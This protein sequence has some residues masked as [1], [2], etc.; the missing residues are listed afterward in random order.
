MSNV[1]RVKRR[2]S[3]GSG[4]PTTLQLGN[5]EIAYNEVDDT[6][7]YGK[8]GTPAAAASVVKVG[9]VGNFLPLTGG[10]LTGSLTINPGNLALGSTFAANTIDL[11]QHVA[12]YSTT[13]GL[14]VS[15]LPQLNLVAGGAAVM[16][17][18]ATTV[19]LPVGTIFAATGS[20]TFNNWITINSN[21]SGYLPTSGQGA[22]GWNFTGGS[23]DIDFFNTSPTAASSFRF[24][25]I[26][27]AAPPRWTGNTA[28]AL[29]ANVQNDANGRIYICTVAGTSAA[30][31]GPTGTGAGIVDGTVTWNFVSASSANASLLVEMLPTLTRFSTG[32]SFGS[33]LGASNADLSKHI[34]LF[35]TNYGINVTS[36]QMNLV[37]AG[38]PTVQIIGNTVKV[39]AGLQLDT[40]Q[41]TGRSL[42]YQASGLNRWA[43]QVLV[44]ESGTGNSGGNISLTRYDDTGAS[45]GI[46][47]NITR[48]SGAIT[49][50]EAA[51]TVTI[52]GALAVT[53][54]PTGPTATVGTN[55]TQLATTA[56]VA[57]AVATIS[58][59]VV[60]F[61]T[62]TGAV[63]L[64]AADVT[65]VGGALLASPTFTGTP[66]A[67]TAAANTNTTQLATTA[68]VVGQAATVAPVM[69]ATAVV[70]T[71]LLYARQ[72]HSHAS[73]TSRV[74]KAG[75]TM[76]G[77]LTISAAAPSLLLNK[78]ASGNANAV[79][80][81]TNNSIRWQI[82]PGNVTAESGSN[83]GSDFGIYRYSDTGAFID[84]PFFIYRS[85][86]VVLFA[87]QLT[88]SSP[89][90]LLPNNSALW[91][92][93]TGAVQRALIYLSSGNIMALGSNSW[94]YTYHYPTAAI[95]PAVDNQQW[96]GTT[97][98]RWAAVAATNGTIQTS[99]VALKREIIPLPTCLDLIERINPI[100]Y[101]W[102]DVAENDADRV[103]WGF[104]AEN[105]RDVIA[106]TGI[107]FGGYIGP[108]HKQPRSPDAVGD[109][110]KSLNYSQL[111]A[112][113]W[114]AVQELTAEVS[115]LKQAGA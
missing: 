43:L 73:D 9:G 57:T 56:F 98:N 68:Y 15:S 65:G 27:T 47:L 70:G 97:S 80:G 22:I 60:S 6:L 115:R 13:Y 49:L 20:A 74:V 69:N 101:R 90:M 36:G 110:P 24:Y 87:Q 34:A 75:D 100:T 89:G 35:G 91:T 54:I 61:N 59:G 40:V 63:T 111:V 1:L 83:A 102:K 104:D 112:V 11:S 85:T 30:S 53:G 4:S 26:T 12:L 79:I 19:T 29:N 21:A 41:S 105:V 108:E 37:V 16:N 82:Q 51:A 77:N 28:Y 52:G 44:A 94:G 25:Q 42:T 46:P 38:N 103:H 81:Y 84:A 55:N 2:L 86:G 23:R 18:T 10:T 33:V 48:S 8:G 72:D 7:W 92:L 31:G 62:R 67:P 96:C 45:L 14:N 64:I 99:D 88:A 39:G 71:S 17:A 66:T 50:G 32:V 93:D 76:T 58:T 106:T 107:D 78:S 95:I 3:G 114:K 113:L 109:P 5:A